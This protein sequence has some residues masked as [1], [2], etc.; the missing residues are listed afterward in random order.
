MY[1][2]F[3]QIDQIHAISI[4]NNHRIDSFVKNE[5]WLNSALFTEK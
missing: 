3:K 5:K 2:G 1:W 4:F